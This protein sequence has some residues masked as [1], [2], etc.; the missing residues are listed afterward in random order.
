MNNSCVTIDTFDEFNEYDFL[1][2]YRTASLSSKAQNLTD[3]VK[4]IS[5]A[6]CLAFS[7]ITAMYDPWTIERK[8]REAAVTMSVYKGIVGRFISRVEALKL[9][10]QILVSAERERLAVA[11]FEAA[12]GIQWGEGE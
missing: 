3:I 7:P 9:V 4:T 11:E 12:K 10:R 6:T 2:K 5:L 8:Q 1:K